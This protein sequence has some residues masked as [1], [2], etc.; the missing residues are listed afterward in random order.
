MAKWPSNPKSRILFVI[1]T[2]WGCFSLHTT[3]DSQVYWLSS[4]EKGIL[5]WQ[6]FPLPYLLLLSVC[7]PRLRHFLEFLGSSH[8]NENHIS[9][10]LILTWVCGAQFWAFEKLLGAGK[11]ILMLPINFISENLHPR[12]RDIYEGK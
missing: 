10:V 1:Q 8:R 3:V 2:S 11:L 12:L 9:Q 5:T 6:M 4:S 7:S